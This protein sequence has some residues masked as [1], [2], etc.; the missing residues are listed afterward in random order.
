MRPRS[1]MRSNLSLKIASLVLAVFVWMYVRSEEKPFQVFSVPL[2][3]E[4]LPK[5]VALAG[6]APDS[7]AVRVRASDTTLR[8]LSPG[9][10]RARVHLE[11]ARPGDLTIPLTPD[12]I[13]APLGVEVVRVDPRTLSLKVERRITKLVPVVARVTGQPAQGFEYA[14]YTADP[15]KVTVEAPEGIAM[16]LSEALTDEVAIGGRSESFDS[17]VNVLPGRAGA[18]VAGRTT[19]N[20]RVNIRQQRMTQ[21]YAGIPLETNTPAGFS[22]RVRFSPQSVTVVLEGTKDDLADITPSS[23]RALLDLEGMGPRDAP[24]LVKPRIVIAPPELA[25]SVMVH[26]L[27]EPTI[28]VSISR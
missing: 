8:N 25:A 11:G 19:V 14:G 2:E 20:L 24:H 3:L 12:I 13:K 10:F 16:G 4:G 26:S 7:V 5:D 6:D 18:R 1:W 23:I 21:A 22:Y 28:N 9:R 15:D 27:S 17:A